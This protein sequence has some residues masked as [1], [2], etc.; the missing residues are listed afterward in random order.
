MRRPPWWS[1]L[2]FVLVA[3][4][5][6]LWAL[7]SAGAGWWVYL[8]VRRDLEA[9]M[10]VQLSAATRLVA[11]QVEAALPRTALTEPGAGPDPALARILDNVRKAGLAE[12]LV[13][14]SGRGLVLVDATG[15]AVPGFQELDLAG[16]D[17][18]RL[19]AGE[20]VVHDPAGAGFG[21]LSQ[22][23]YAPLKGGAVLELRVD[24]AYLAVLRRFR[25][26][27]LWT[28]TLGLCC[29]AL[30]GAALAAWILSPLAWLQGAVRG[31]TPAGPPGGGHELS[32]AAEAVAGSLQSLALQN[33]EA[34]LLREHAERRSEELRQVAS[35]IAHEVRNPLT[36]IRGQA[37]LL[38]RA[39]GPQAGAAAPLDR[40]REQVGRLDHV[41]GRFLELGRPPRFEPRR[42]DLAALLQRLADTLRQ[43]APSDAWSVAV[44]APEPCQAPADPTLLEGALLNL[45]LNAL[46]AM[47]QGGPV[48]LALRRLDDRLCL[49]VRDHGAGFADG[50]REHLFEPF[51]TTKASGSGLGLALARRAAQAHGGGLE[52]LDAPGGG[53][54]FRLWL[55]WPGEGA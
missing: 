7:L 44:D 30:L 4:Q 38:G 2:R 49:D 40:I 55:P 11:R 46:Q 9:A 10:A 34:R 15:E 41:V 14:L 21:T 45:G 52:A 16:E 42:M 26:A 35:A 50:V 23:A 12:D 28:G 27:S 48:E 32:Q 22:S 1:S 37:D 53:A 20:T 39:L 19:R 3:S 5:A 24:P 43:S 17:W 13:L 31:E 54:L 36:V 8:G 25:R 18:R 33:Q 6:G 47:P 51:F 29:S